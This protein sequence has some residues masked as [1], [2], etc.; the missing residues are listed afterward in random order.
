MLDSSFDFSRVSRVMFRPRS[1]S[2]QTSS[3]WP[4][5]FS[6][7]I[8]T[9]TIKEHL[10]QKCLDKVLESLE[11]CKWKYEKKEA[12]PLCLVDFETLEIYSHQDWHQ[13]CRIQHYWVKIESDGNEIT[14]EAYSIPDQ[15]LREVSVGYSRIFCYNGVQLKE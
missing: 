6:Y 9:K 10:C 12:V 1:W 13:G 14:V 2:I 8:N 11:F 3:V 7:Q 4:I 15:K 5:P